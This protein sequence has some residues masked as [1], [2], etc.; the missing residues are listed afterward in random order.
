MSKIHFITI[1]ASNKYE[2]PQPALDIYKGGYWKVVKEIT[3]LVDYTWILSAK[4]GLIS[5]NQVIK[6]YK[7]SF[8]PDSPDYIGHKGLKPT[9]YWDSI[10]CYNESSSLSNLI[11]KYPQ[12]M[13]VMYASFSYMKAIKNDILPVINQPNLYIFS[14]DT[15]GKDFT[16]YILKT[17]L[18]AKSILGGNKINIT[19]LTIKHFLE[20]INTIGWDKKNINTYFKNMVKDQPEYEFKPPKQKVNDEFIKQLILDI[21]IETPKTTLLKNISKKGYACGPNRFHRILNNLKK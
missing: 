14:P 7:L 16:P 6:P 17:S 18:K 10:N 3:N 13:F 12:D 21:G 1:C 9:E 19:A 20:N 2:T 11:N 8:K 5:S 15:K 4:Y